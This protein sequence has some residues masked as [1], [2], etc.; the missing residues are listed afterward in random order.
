MEVPGGGFGDLY[1]LLIMIGLLLCWI[2]IQIHSN[3][4]GTERGSELIRL[5]FNVFKIGVSAIE[6]FTQGKIGSIE[7]SWEICNA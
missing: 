2:S 6:K 4:R 3:V 5:Y 7:S 1:R